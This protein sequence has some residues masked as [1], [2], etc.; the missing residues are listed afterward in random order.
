MTVLLVEDP[1][2]VRRARAALGLGQRELAEVLGV[3][4]TAVQRWEAGQRAV[5][6]PVARL[7][8]LLLRDR[9]LLALLR[10]GA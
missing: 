6:G 7:L 5:G 4:I 9:A 3:N 1:G 8:A 10:A 2:A